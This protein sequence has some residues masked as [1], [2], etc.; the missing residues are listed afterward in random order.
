M[1]VEENTSSL[2]SKKDKERERSV[3]GKERDGEKQES[4]NEIITGHDC[5]NE[6]KVNEG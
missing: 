3:R 5:C 6:T 2:G 1:S 4:E